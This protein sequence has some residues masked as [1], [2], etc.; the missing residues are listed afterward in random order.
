ME[1]G[2]GRKRFWL[3]CENYPPKAEVELMVSSRERDRIRYTDREEFTA[4]MMIKKI[5]HRG[6]FGVTEEEEGKWCP[7]VGECGGCMFSSVKYARQL[8]EKRSWLQRAFPTLQYGMHLRA[9]PQI[10]LVRGTRGKSVHERNKKVCVPDKVQRCLPAIH[11]HREFE[12]S[13]EWCPHY[14]RGRGP[15]GYGRGGFEADVET[16]PLSCSRLPKR[17]FRAMREA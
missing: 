9:I 13:A 15:A 5:L 10:D 7:H 14:G 6:R 3:L 16:S 12:Y 17:L 2:M 1:V 8:I 11:G 4:G